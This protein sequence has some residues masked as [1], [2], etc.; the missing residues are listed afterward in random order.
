MP[1]GVPRRPHGER[2]ATGILIR[3]PSIVPTLSVPMPRPIMEEE[4][5]PVPAYQLRRNQ[6]TGELQGGWASGWSK[7]ASLSSR[8]R[9]RAFRGAMCHVCRGD[10]RSPTCS[11]AL[12][13]S[14]VADVAA[15]AK[16]WV[17]K[18]AGVVSGANDLARRRARIR[19]VVTALRGIQSRG[20]GAG[21]RG[22]VAAG[23]VLPPR[24]R[25]PKCLIAVRHFA[26][27]P[28]PVFATSESVDHA[29]RR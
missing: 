11:P 17:S 28:K 29:V 13:G 20:D 22:C 10:L 9:T 26:A 6:V 4:N 16:R 8:I 2:T 12:N 23:A 3:E 21:R 18:V 19:E 14:I 25:Q 24:G 1:A 5:C 27:V 15:N 7:T